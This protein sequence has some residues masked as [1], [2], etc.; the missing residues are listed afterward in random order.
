MGLLNFKKTKKGD[1]FF[2]NTGTI[3][4]IGAGVLI[5]EIQQTSDKGMGF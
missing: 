5:A 2:I 3:H 4:A 1:S